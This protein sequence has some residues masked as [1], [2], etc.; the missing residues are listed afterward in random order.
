MG[1]LR[2]RIPV[3]YWTM[4]AGVVAIAGIPPL[5]GFFAKYYVFLAAIEAKL[6]ALAIIGVVASVVGAYYYLRIVKLMWFDDAKGGFEKAA[7]EL[8]I[9]YALS[10]LFV[11][12]FIFFGGVGF[13]GSYGA[14]AQAMSIVS[15][16]LLFPLSIVWLARGTMKTM[17]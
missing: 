3:T 17:P 9:V 15:E 11:I 13:S 10:G 7:G 5:A 6:Y 8:R 1:G 16:L 4:T 2:K 14:M 12:A